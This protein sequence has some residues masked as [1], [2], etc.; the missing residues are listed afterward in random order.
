MAVIKQSG[1][2]KTPYRLLWQKNTNGTAKLLRIY[3]TTSQVIVP[4]EIE[5]HPVTE[6]ASYCFAQ[7]QHFPD[8]ETIEETQS[9]S[10]MVQT[11]LQE[12]CG[13]S[14]EE[15]YLPDTICKIGRYAFYNCKNLKIIH[16][17]AAIEDIGSDAFMNTTSFHKIIL[18]CSPDGKSGI[19]SILSQISADMEVQFQTGQ[20][21]EA[22][23]LY[24]EY[25]ESY[26]EIAPAHL[27]GRSITGEGFR[28]RQ[29]IKDDRVDF[30]GYDAIFPQA[31][32]EE[33]EKTLSNIALNRLR[34][35]YALQENAKEA[36]RNYTK[37]HIRYIGNCLIKHKKL[38]LLHFLCQEGLLGGTNLAECVQM[39][40]E[41]DW[42]EGAA[43]LLQYQAVAGQER[44]KN[45]Y[46]FG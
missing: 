8:G 40:A 5:G 46:D 23:L 14:I 41:T 19:R 27:F 44:K 34:Y 32:V 26:D 3:G 35:P 38:E 39:A 11:S 36:Y 24:P 43:S 25:Y 6:L 42:P 9:D 22:L 20:G 13:A 21:V 15:V 30:A 29:C 45:R 18:R 1:T 2:D 31:C 33:S 37:E 16:I 10:K 17:G 7:T 28:A 4:A 12:L